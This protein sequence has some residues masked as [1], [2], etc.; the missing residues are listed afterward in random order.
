MDVRPSSRRRAAGTQF[1]LD[2]R[3]GSANLAR[4]KRAGSPDVGLRCFRNLDPNNYAPDLQDIEARWLPR[5]PHHLPHESSRQRRRQYSSVTRS[6]RVVTKT[7]GKTAV[8]RTRAGQS[9][10]Q[11][12]ECGRPEV[13]RAQPAACLLRLADHSRF[14]ST[15]GCPCR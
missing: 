2:W 6:D 12:K 9:Q 13:G 11:A 7:L 8:P 15:K 1:F 14:Q 5:R 4:Y 10:R 3:R